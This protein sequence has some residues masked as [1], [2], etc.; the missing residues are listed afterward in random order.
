MTKTGIPVDDPTTITTPA[1]A[2]CRILGDLTPSFR[3]RWLIWMPQNM[4]M[5][6]RL[7][8][9]T[10]QSIVVHKEPLARGW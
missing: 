5:R 10:L 2:R 8:L 4:G 7:R 9:S 3:M 1:G 6:G